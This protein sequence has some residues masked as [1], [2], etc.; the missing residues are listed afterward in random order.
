M[1][2]YDN[3][4]DMIIRLPLKEPRMSPYWLNGLLLLVKGRLLTEAERDL[5]FLFCPIPTS[6][7]LSFNVS[8]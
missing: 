7:C 6:Q 3:E 2:F 5:K 1:E 4:T 8:C